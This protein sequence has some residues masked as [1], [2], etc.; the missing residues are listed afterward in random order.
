MGKRESIEGLPPPM[1]PLPLSECTN[2]P[3]SGHPSR[4]PARP[5]SSRKLSKQNQQPPFLLQQQQQPVGVNRPNGLLSK[6]FRKGPSKAPKLNPVGISSKDY[7]ADGP[8][9]SAPIPILPTEGGSV[10][11]KSA[12]LTRKLS[13]VS[14]ALSQ[15]VS[16]LSAVATPHSLT[17]KSTNAPGVTSFSYDGIHEPGDMG[18]ST[19]TLNTPPTSSDNQRPPPPGQN[20]P[21]RQIS[22]GPSMAQ[23]PP[24]PPSR[25]TLDPQ[26]PNARV[27]SGSKQSSPSSETL[28]YSSPKSLG[29]SAIPSEDASPNYPANSSMMSDAP[30]LHPATALES[31]KYSGT[32]APEERKRRG[33]L[34]RTK[35]GF[36]NI[37]RPDT[38][39]QRHQSYDKNAV[40]IAAHPQMYE[41]SPLTSVP[42]AAPATSHGQG[43]DARESPPSFEALLGS[44]TSFA[45]LGQGNVVSGLAQT[46]EGSDDMSSVGNLGTIDKDFLLTIQRNSALEARRQRRR[47][48]RRN[49]LSF[50][51]TGDKSV[52]SERIALDLSSHPPLQLG[53]LP[54]LPSSAAASTTCAPVSLAPQGSGD[55][56]KS[57]LSEI[58]HGDKGSATCLDHHPHISEAAKIATDQQTS[59]S[60]CTAASVCSNGNNGSKQNRHSIGGSISRRSAGRLSFSAKSENPPSLKRD[61]GPRGSIRR[62]TMPSNSLK[63]P[64]PLSSDSLTYSETP[65]DSSSRPSSSD[66]DRQRQEPVALHRKTLSEAGGAF[67]KKKSRHLD[68]L[69]NMPGSLPA[70]RRDANCIDLPPPVPPLPLNSVLQAHNQNA[71][72][73]AKSPPSSLRSV[74]ASDGDTPRYSLSSR[75][76]RNP[77]STLP[78]ALSISPR[79]TQRSSQTAPMLS[80][81]PADG[82][83][84]TNTPP[85]HYRQHVH[86][87]D[88][89][90]NS[91]WDAAQAAG[92]YQ[93]RISASGQGRAEPTKRDWLPIYHPQSVSHANYSRKFSHP[94]AELQSSSNPPYSP[95]GSPDIL[96]KSASNLAMRLSMDGGKPNRINNSRGHKHGISKFFSVAPS[97]RKAQQQKNLPGHGF[98]S[99]MPN[100][101]PAS[102]QHQPEQIIYTDPP[103]SPVVSSLVGDPLARRRIRDQLA[104][105]MAFDRLLEEDDEFTMAISLTPTV[106]GASQASTYLSK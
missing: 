21:E 7:F 53:A 54:A 38:R 89:Q 70:V 11:T 74:G 104:S 95:V 62:S 75:K 101:K 69:E 77:I 80:P 16:L 35:L 90:D 60:I 65:V 61:D 64:R 63:K 105:S 57:S 99:P 84:A 19:H 2:N 87:H 43:I 17:P 40:D 76:Y 55:G 48:T 28:S 41:E 33:S 18:A 51:G 67:M 72:Q 103:T 37:R 45:S 49:T 30:V 94:D 81:A 68:T 58:R 4:M 42:S 25:P 24:R 5:W 6:M 91:D 88:I 82:A 39:R 92:L 93:Y 12:K 32:Q 23:S 13:G 59:T 31:E 36:T 85:N 78:P 86:G 47:D 106:A 14:P 66:G 26:S 9:P 56:G 102:S 3:A 10:L 27:P 71:R 1:P 98:M 15:S 44:K 52:F 73:T 8:P 29:S 96:S 97:N 34:W 100:N 79:D 50:L 46:D 20:R 83:G 22:P